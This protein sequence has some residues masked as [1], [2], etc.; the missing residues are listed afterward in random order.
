MEAAGWVKRLYERTNNL[1]AN[2]KG[3]LEK[4][5]I[6][7]QRLLL[8]DICVFPELLLEIPIEKEGALTVVISKFAQE[9]GK[10]EERKD[11]TL[12]ERRTQ[13][14]LQIATYL[15]FSNAPLTFA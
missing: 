2:A 15:L 14:A 3:D 13:Y 8:S 1:E 12:N 11:E 6:K 7:Q 10:A 9:L 5:Q 4:L